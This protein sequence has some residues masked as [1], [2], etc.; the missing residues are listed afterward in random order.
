MHDDNDDKFTNRNQPNDRKKLCTMEG[1]DDPV[2]Y[3]AT[4]IAIGM[5]VGL[6]AETFHR[7][8][9]LINAALPVMLVA[10]GLLHWM[11]RRRGR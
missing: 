9:M 5:Y 6:L 3:V 10:I 11:H 2:W 4:F 7:G 8:D 1:D